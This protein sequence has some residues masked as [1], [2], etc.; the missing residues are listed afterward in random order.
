MLKFSSGSAFCND[1]EFSKFKFFSL[2]FFLVSLYPISKA[3]IKSRYSTEFGELAY[4]INRSI[5]IGLDLSL[6]E[7]VIHGVKK[8]MELI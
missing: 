6:V 7:E 8:G 5:K 4:R 1:L 2:L 3:Q